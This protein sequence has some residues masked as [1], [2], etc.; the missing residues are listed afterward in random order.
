MSILDQARNLIE[1]WDLEKELITTMCPWR[2]VVEKRKC[3]VRI[4]NTPTLNWEYVLEVYMQQDDISINLG[5]LY[6]VTI[7]EH[8]YT[9]PRDPIPTFFAFEKSW[10]VEKIVACPKNINPNS[11]LFLPALLHE[12]WHTQDKIDWWAKN[13]PKIERNAWANAIKI[14]RE[15]ERKWIQIKKGISN[16]DLQKII[17]TA[18]R[19][20]TKKYGP[21]FLKWVR[22]EIA[23][24]F[25]T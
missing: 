21:G 5:E 10:N 25:I 15:L 18:L 8:N 3:S 24:F 23:T 19:S 17:I 7:Y 6:G 13:W 1:Y 11:L 2:V 12:I 16:E 22:E 14:L 4:E 9:N 20:H